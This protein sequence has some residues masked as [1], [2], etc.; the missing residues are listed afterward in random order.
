MGAMVTRLLSASLAAAAALVLTSPASAEAP[1]RADTI[2]FASHVTATKLRHRWD[3]ARH[4]DAALAAC[5]EPK[6]AEAVVLMS[7]VGQKRV[8]L[9][10]GSAAQQAHAARA[11]ETLDARRA[12]L[13]TESTA[14]APHVYTAIGGTRVTM[15]VLRSIAVVDPG[16]GG[17]SEPELLRALLPPNTGR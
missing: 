15:T 1:S 8:E 14:C 11:L 7:R 12:E 13:E 16:F 2:A 5:L 3:D 4:K 17:A 9:R 10:D 6:V